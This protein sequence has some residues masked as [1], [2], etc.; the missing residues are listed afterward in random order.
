MQG[1]LLPRPLDLSPR[2]D[3]TV[4][5]HGLLVV[6]RLITNKQ[7]K[8]NKDLFSLETSKTPLCHLMLGSSTLMVL[9]SWCSRTRG[10][11]RCRGS[12]QGPDVVL[13]SEAA[14]GKD[15]VIAGDG[16]PLVLPAL[17]PGRS[18]E[19]RSE[20]GGAQVHG[21]LRVAGDTGVLRHGRPHHTRQGSVWGF[22]CFLAF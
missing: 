22:R 21:L 16:R 6:A 12:P 7:R 8:L 20:L 15:D 17:L 1:Y 2:R 11:L 13:E 19:V 9:A 4:P 10:R 5:S 18:H 3:P 14:H